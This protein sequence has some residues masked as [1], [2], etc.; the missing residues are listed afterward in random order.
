MT[1]EPSKDKKRAH[2][3]FILFLFLIIVIDVLGIHG[4]GTLQASAV[5]SAQTSELKATLT[6]SQKNSLA[7]ETSWETMF[8]GFSGH[9]DIALYNDKTGEISRYTNYNG[10]FDTASIIKL[11]ILEDLL[12]QDQK[13]GINITD[14]Q[15]GEATPM[16]ENSDNDAASALWASIGGA[17]AINSYYKQIGADS[18]TASDTNGWGL[19]QTT[20]LDQLKVLNTLAYPGKTLTTASSAIADNLLDQ[21]EADQTWGVSGGVPSD[22]SFELKDGWLPD[23]ETND[24]FSS[25]DD[26]TVNSIGHVHGDGVDYTLAVLTEGDITEQDGINTIQSV[27]STAWSTLDSEK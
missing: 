7:L 19:T 20:A 9:I 11:S 1:V 8:K 12:V 5:Q 23:N 13:A 24:S 17:S 22:V 3:G 18:S 6:T 16:I 4:Y 14:D 10:T 27:A 15:L 21:V 26:W 25:T 2:K